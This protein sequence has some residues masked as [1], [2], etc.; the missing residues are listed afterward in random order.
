MT[1]TLSIWW[2]T[3]QD[4]YLIG[5][6]GPS[7]AP[8]YVLRLY[9]RIYAKREKLGEGEPLWVDPRFGTIELNILQ[10]ASAKEYITKFS[11]EGIV[12]EDS[13]GLLLSDIGFLTTLDGNFLKS[14]IYSFSIEWPHGGSSEHLF[15]GVWYIIFGEFQTDE[16]GDWRVWLT[17]DEKSFSV[18]HSDKS[19]LDQLGSCIDEHKDLAW[20]INRK[21]KAAWAVVHLTLRHN[22]KKHF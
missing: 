5:P 22:G 15:E 10:D 9:R 17:D 18:T 12:V 8:D 11:V 21:M 3:K 19:K 20:S 4:L 7:N 6:N 2:L 16:P 13:D 1:R 14:P